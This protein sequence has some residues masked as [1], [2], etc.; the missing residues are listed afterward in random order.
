MDRWLDNLAA[1]SAPGASSVKIARNKPQELTEGCW[2]TDGEKIAESLSYHGA[3]RCQ[4]L[5]PSYGDPRTAAGGPP[6]RRCPE[7]RTE[8]RQSR[9]LPSSAHRRAACTPQDRFFPSVVC[10]YTQPG[11]GQ[12]LIPAAWQSH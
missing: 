5:Y 8:A 2:A 10:D 3:G 12:T 7:V 11:V 4:A 9:G 1:D 6:D